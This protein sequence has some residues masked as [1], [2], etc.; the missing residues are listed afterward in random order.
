MADNTSIAKAELSGSIV[1]IKPKISLGIS[2]YNPKPTK[3]DLLLLDEK[4]AHD[5]HCEACGASIT[6][7]MRHAIHC[8]GGWF[9]GCGMCF[10]A[11]NLDLIPHFERG[12]ILYFPAMTQARLNS[13]LRAV[14]SVE[15]FSRVGVSDRAF[16]EFKHAMAEI[17]DKINGQ[18]HGMTVYFDST[19]VDVFV[20]MLDLLRPEEYEQRHKLTENFRW[21]PKRE[22]FKNEL[23]YWSQQDFS[24]LHPSKIDDNISSFM[25]KYLK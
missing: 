25:A 18:L 21:Y 13:V 2:T 19:N 7:E 11:Q 15:L 5:P 9:N 14:W 24:A 20:A 8:E 17:I 3:E 23:P 10:Y 12:D 1:K 6:K 4:L 16:S 22:I